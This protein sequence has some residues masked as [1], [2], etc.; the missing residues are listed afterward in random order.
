MENIDKMYSVEMN[1]VDE[2]DLS[3]KGMIEEIKT[4]FDIIRLCLQEKNELDKQ[5]LPMLDR[6]LVMPLRKLLCEDS[7]VL[8][9]VC[10]NFKMPPIK[11]VPIEFLDNQTIIRPP[12][13]TVEPTKRWILVKQW[14]EQ[15]ISW[16]D[17][18]ANSIAKMI[19]EYSYKYIM[20]KLGGRKYRQLKS[21]FESLFYNKQVEYR[22][23][24]KEVYC[25]KNPIDA[26]ANKEIYDILE[27][28]GYNKLSVYDFIKHMSDK[29]GAHID[30]GHSLVVEL[31]NKSDAA[32]FTPVHYF[33][34]QMIY[35]AKQ[36]IPELVDYWTEMPDLK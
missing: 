31:V 15:N 24:V 3:H 19:P 18:D 29:R 23:E 9:K 26:I 28:I 11:G 33:A 35:A 20:Q 27:Q 22:G 14:L 6:I 13:T 10:P 21:K 2:L 32:G 12:F 5:Y 4:E 25:K 30:V 16:F 36:Q 8:L 1:F 17:R 34:I 7:S